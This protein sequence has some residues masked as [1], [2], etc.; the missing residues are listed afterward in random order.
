MPNNTTV[1]EADILEMLFAPQAAR[2]SPEAAR[3]FLKLKFDGDTT[4]QIRQLLRKNN[5]GSISAPERT[6][7]ERN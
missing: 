4:K 5:R 7:S 1:S 6:Q 2:L 3:F